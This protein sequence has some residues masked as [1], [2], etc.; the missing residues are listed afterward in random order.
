MTQ[1]LTPA[2]SFKKVRHWLSLLLTLLL[3]WYIAAY[4]IGN[5]DQFRYLRIIGALYIVYLFGIFMV[6]QLELS[7]RTLVV[8]RRLGLEKMPFSNWFRIF[9]LARFFN[10]VMPQGG[11]IY[12]G[13]TLKTKH[14]FSIRNYVQSYFI[15]TA[16]E[17]VVNFLLT[18]LLLAL[19][20]SGL[21]LGGVNIA[22]ASLG[23][24]L[25]IIFLPALVFLVL[26]KYTGSNRFL[27]FVGEY[28]SQ[29]ATALINLRFLSCY[30]LLCVLSFLINVFWFF[31][32]FKSLGTTV[33]LEAAVI[34]PLLR[35]IGLM[36]NLTPASIGILELS[37][38]YF[39]QILGLDFSIGLVVGAL[40]RCVGFISIA[41]LGGIFGGFPMIKRLK[42][43]KREKN[44]PSSQALD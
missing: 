7:I 17:L 31:I 27:K 21:N 42:E 4:I 20:F 28:M 12:R 3:L 10:Q 39:T 19:F 6:I 29:M 23:T 37:F 14:R 16:L 43:K 36:I 24:A 34:F 40:T 32:A 33:G 15:A 22:A 9:S 26:R 13:Y 35:R 5:W 18:A 30:M 11:N 38:A 2:D 8:M 25:T 44:N 41:A 1:V